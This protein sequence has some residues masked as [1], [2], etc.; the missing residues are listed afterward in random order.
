[1]IEHLHNINRRHT[2][3]EMLNI[4]DWLSKAVPI[5][6]CLTRT[7]NSEA[8]FFLN[9]DILRFVPAFC[10]W[11]LII[12]RRPMVQ[13]H[14]YT[15]LLN[16]KHSMQNNVNA[17]TPRPTC[18]F[19]EIIIWN[20][21]IPIDILVPLCL[22]NE[23]RPIVFKHSYTRRRN[24][25]ICQ[26]TIIYSACR[27]IIKRLFFIICNHL[28]LLKWLLFNI[29]NPLPLKIVDPDLFLM[30]VKCCS[31]LHIFMG[32]LI[33]CLRISHQYHALHPLIL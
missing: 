32:C 20:Q 19:F 5:L 30:A 12:T 26:C 29:C 17:L 10:H 23:L 16:A 24:N 4:I 28:P 9:V 22:I 7:S 18:Q 1:M 33:S 31:T 27:N 21:I 13:Q 25:L 14:N 11:T 6:R 8:T 2:P 15:L 3:L